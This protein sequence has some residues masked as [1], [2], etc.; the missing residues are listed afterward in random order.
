[1]LL[2]QGGLKDV[3]PGPMP[4]PQQA[5][6][7]RSDFGSF[8]GDNPMDRPGEG[9]PP[10]GED[11]PGSVFGKFDPAGASEAALDPTAASQNPG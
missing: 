11:E 10:G 1:M 2:D 8:G 3:G 7:S 5:P 4:Q 9:R 6:R